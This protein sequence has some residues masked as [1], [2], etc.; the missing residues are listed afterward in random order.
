MIALARHLYRRL[1][2]GLVLISPPLLYAV[3]LLAVPV[4]AV[5]ALSFWSQDYLEIQ[6]DLTFVNYQTAWTGHVYQALMLRSIKIALLVSIAT[7]LLA[8]PMAYFLSFHVADHRKPLWLFLITIPF[9]TSYLV[10]IFLWKVILGYNGVINGSLTALGLVD[11]PLRFILYN[12]AAVVMTLSHAWVPFAVLPIY[13][14]LEKIDRSLLEV[15]EDLGDGHLRRFCRITLPLAMPGV[16]AATLIVFIPTVGDYITPN[17]VGGPNGLMIAN[18]IEVQFKK[19]NN[20][21]LGAALALTAMALVGA[22]ALLLVWATRK[23]LRV[24]T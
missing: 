2:P 24:P 16:I 17:L 12:Q 6:R 22:I 8:F 13:V 20:E 19:A 10:R 9:W 11:E 15:A 21:P 14:A 23:Y 4:A 7:V 1:N 18:M 3:I 5:V